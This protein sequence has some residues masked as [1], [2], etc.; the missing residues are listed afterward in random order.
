MRKSI[1][2]GFIAESIK[3]APW[4]LCA[5]RWGQCGAHSIVAEWMPA[6]ALA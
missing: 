6:K 1:L 3:M 5:P 2:I 4:R